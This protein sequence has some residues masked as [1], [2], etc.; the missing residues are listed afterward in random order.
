[1]KGPEPQ[2]CEGPKSKFKIVDT[3]PSGSGDCCHGLGASTGPTT[4]Q[5]TNA[6]FRGQASCHPRRSGH[7]S[8]GIHGPGLL[9]VVEFAF[10]RASSYN[11]CTWLQRALGHRSKVTPRNVPHK[12]KETAGFFLWAFGVWRTISPRIPLDM[13]VSKD[14]IRWRHCHVK[15]SAAKC[16]A[17]HILMKKWKAISCNRRLTKKTR[18]FP[19]TPAW[20]CLKHKACWGHRPAQSFESPT[21]RG[22]VQKILVQGQG[23]VSCGSRALPWASSETGHL[24]GE[25]WG[26]NSFYRP[27]KLVRLIT[28]KYSRRMSGFCE[29][30]LLFL[31]NKPQE[32]ALW[33]E[34]RWGFFCHWPLVIK[35]ELRTFRWCRYSLSSRERLTQSNSPWDDIFT[36]RRFIPGHQLFFQVKLQF[37]CSLDLS[38]HPLLRVVR[39]DSHSFKMQ[40]LFECFWQVKK[41]VRPSERM[42]QTDCRR[43]QQQNHSMNSRQAITCFIP[44]FL[45]SCKMFVFLF[46]AEPNKTFSFVSCFTNA[47]KKLLQYDH[48]SYTLSFSETL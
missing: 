43:T 18:E 34:T 45:R 12:L 47:T 32:C 8:L 36:R 23:C 40:D 10:T 11:I 15:Q 44:G 7:E 42:L 24:C 9:R 30:S 4:L 35:H 38:Q 1:M 29:Q 5:T 31:Q 3:V 13:C 41:A 27:E 46:Q 37:L 22:S 2:I 28:L 21:L 48:N 26:F 14:L 6:L 20:N 33:H 25:L 17:L 16:Y 19:V 39:K